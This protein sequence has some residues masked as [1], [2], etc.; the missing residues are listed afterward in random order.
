MKDVN[1]I[2]TLFDSAICP[3]PSGSGDGA[4][5]V[6]GVSIPDGQKGTGG[7]MPEVSGVSLPDDRSTGG[8]RPGDMAGS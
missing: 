7:E 8:K 2:Q 3:V 4:K 6:G 1:G 5:D